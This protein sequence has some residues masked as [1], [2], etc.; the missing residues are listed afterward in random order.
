VYRQN[1]LAF[2][3]INEQAEWGYWY[4][5]TKDTKNV[6]YQSGQDTVVRAAFEVNGALPNK[7][8]TQ[9][10]AIEDKFPVFGFAVNCGEVSKTPQETV[11]VLGLTQEHAIQFAGKD[12]T[13]ALPSLWTSY[14]SSA[15]EAVSSSIQFVGTCSNKV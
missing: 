11:F 8:D 15:T 1:Q 4:W 14:F 5:A 13:V 9:F 2:T 12:G 7:N 3:E 10:R 6:T